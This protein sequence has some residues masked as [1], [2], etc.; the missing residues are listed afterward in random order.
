MFLTRMEKL[1]KAHRCALFGIC[2]IIIMATF[3]PITAHAD[4][5]G[6]EIYDV[7]AEITKETNEINDLMSKAFQFCTVSPYTI[8]NSYMLNN[9]QAVAQQILAANKTVALI[10]ATLLLMVDF[11]KKSTTFEWASKWENILLFIV[12]IIL[13]KQVVQNSDAIAG[14]IYALFN[15]INTEALALPFSEFLPASNVHDYNIQVTNEFIGTL[16]TNSFTKNW[17]ECWVLGM[18]DLGVNLVG[19]HHYLISEDAV[20]MFYPHAAFPGDTTIYYQDAKTK[21]LNPTES[22][23]YN[24]TLELVLYVKPYFLLLRAITYLIFVMT[25]GRVFELMLYTFFAPLPLATFAGDSTHE[26]GKSFL[27][28]YIAVI[29]QITVIIVMFIMYFAVRNYL[30]SMPIFTG[31]KFLE[32]IC[33]GVLGFS[34]FKSGTWARQICGLGG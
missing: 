31:T 28:S 6:I 4:V 3:F 34:I 17:I 11:F 18:E 15:Y 14:D 20:K 33:A 32:V 22:V 7:Y 27:K 2:V 30:L 16:S 21:F 19:D 26:V 12:K 1:R 13:V 5:F 9:H 8:V 23:N 29:L 10:I 24:P 25:I